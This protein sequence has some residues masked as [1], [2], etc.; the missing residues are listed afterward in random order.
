[1][2]AI[3]KEDAPSIPDEVSP[4]EDSIV[5]HGETQTQT[6]SGIRTIIVDS[7]TYERCKRQED[8]NG[9]FLVSSYDGQPAMRISN[10]CSGCGMRMF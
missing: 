10:I 5:S 8:S 6:Y 2:K 1:M 9:K 4:C 7:K 3:V